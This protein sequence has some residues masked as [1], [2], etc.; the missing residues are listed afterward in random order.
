MGHAWCETYE[1][2]SGWRVREHTI[3]DVEETVTKPTQ[4][5]QNKEQQQ[6]N[7]TQD[8]QVGGTSATQEDPWA[9]LPPGLSAIYKPRE[10]MSSYSFSG[11]AD[12][13]DKVNLYGIIDKYGVI[14]S[15]LLIILW[16]TCILCALVFVVRLWHRLR[17]SR[18]RASFQ[19]RKGNRGILNIYNE[20]IDM[21]EYASKKGKYTSLDSYKMN[22]LTERE[23]AEHLAEHFTALTQEEWMWIYDCAQRAAYGAD[24]LPKE[25]RKEMY[26]L[27]QKLRDAILRELPKNAKRW[28]LY[29]RGM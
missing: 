21:C 24:L 9:D 25:E 14:G 27:Y 8:Q 23:Y 11:G 16:P 28:F 2:S 10:D 4:A 15:V 12:I 6:G 26:C 22:P 29:G 18:K 17:R 19:I 3:A 5:P 7:N 13:A 1:G 20:I